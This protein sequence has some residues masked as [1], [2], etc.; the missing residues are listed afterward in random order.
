M[1]VLW[2]LVLLFLLLVPL[3]IALYVWLLRRKRRFAVRYSNVALIR[4][5]LPK[6]AQWRRH[7]P[8]ALL[9]VA[10]TALITAMAR[11]VAQVQV[12]LSQASIILAIDVSRSMCATDVLPNRLTV[13]QEAMNSFIDDQADST[14]IGIVAFTGYAQIVVPQTNDKEQ[15]HAAV[16]SFTTAIG[17]AMG[18]AILKSI[19]SIAET[20][21]SVLP[22]GMDLS[23]AKEN[24]EAADEGSLLSQLDVEETGYQ[25]DIIVVLTDGASTRGI[26]P[27]VAAEQAVDRK[28]RV[29]T[30]GFGTQDPGQMICT[31]EQLGGDVFGP[32]SGGFGDGIRGDRGGN[33]WGGGGGGG[34]Y[35]RYLLLD[36]PTLRGVADMTGG[37]YF[38]AEDAQQLLD[39]FLNLPN[40]VEMQ[41]ENREISVIFTALGALFSTLAVGLS[42]LWNRFP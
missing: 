37:E 33:G 23:A 26:E 16:N 22:S 25:P 24:G 21:E 1:N 27:L 19:D 2:P 40:H 29:Y 12:P 9:M 4:A 10:V 13:A 7:I 32:G 41:T 5:A 11:P 36:E 28:I 38:L 6:R 35:R 8:F 31:R 34:G 15:L 39:V 3:L 42:L 18:S 17:T 20:N 30:I 14:R